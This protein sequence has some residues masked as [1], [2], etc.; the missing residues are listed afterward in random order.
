MYGRVIALDHH[1]PFLEIPLLALIC[2]HN[3]KGKRYLHISFPYSS[4]WNLST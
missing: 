1:D 3:K 2:T 4:K